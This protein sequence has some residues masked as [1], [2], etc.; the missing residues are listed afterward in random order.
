MQ[1]RQSFT[2]VPQ[3]ETEQ[4]ASKHKEEKAKLMAD[5]EALT[6]ALTETQATVAEREAAHAQLQQHCKELQVC[7]T[8]S[9]CRLKV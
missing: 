1:S 7:L 6:A 8:P 4:L 9:D 5:L 3:A 2:H